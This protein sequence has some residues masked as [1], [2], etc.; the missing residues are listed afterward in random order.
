MSIRERFTPQ[1]LDT[2]R[3]Y[4]E[5]LQEWK[6]RRPQELTE[7]EKLEIIDFFKSHNHI[8]PAYEGKYEVIVDREDDSCDYEIKDYALERWRAE[9]DE[10][11]PYSEVTQLL[12]YVELEKRGLTPEEYEERRQ[13]ARTPQNEEELKSWKDLEAI[14]KENYEKLEIPEFDIKRAIFFAWV[15]KLPEKRQEEIYDEIVA[16]VIAPED[17]NEYKTL[18]TAIDELFEVNETALVLFKEN[19]PI[20]SVTRDEYRGAF[21]PTKNDHAYILDQGQL[22][23][24]FDENGEFKSLET[25]E[26]KEGLKKRL[27]ETKEA[28]A[29]VID[30]ALYATIA[31]A[32]LSS[33]PKINGHE[34][35]VYAPLFFSALGKQFRKSDFRE[36][37]TAQDR[38]TRHADVWSELNKLEGKTGYLDGKL[39]AVYKYGGYDPKTNILTIY[40]PYVVE[41]IKTMKEKPKLSKK[42]TVEPYYNLLINAN[43]NKE[44]NKIGVQLVL[45][46]VPGIVKR[47]II[48]DYEL[49]KENYKKRKLKDH[50][51]ITYKIS[52]SSLIDKTPLL[53]EAFDNAEAKNKLV[54]LNRALKSFEKYMKTDTQCFGKYKDFSI[55]I[56]PPSMKTLDKDYLTITHH[57]ENEDFKNPNELPD[58]KIVEKGSQD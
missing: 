38:K 18:I 13:K 31:S 55:T 14:Y 37:N 35:Q 15:K 7:I 40:T 8:Y 23:F 57:G 36:N 25:V 10:I 34:I 29:D 58:V 33:L 45:C 49:E 4:R 19:S 24:E 1:A 21:L 6:E 2:L 17:E 51:L 3:I 53:K 30:S 50:K 11:T 16:P 46:V 5:K 43:I 28:P 39:F 20:F 12:Y 41:L 44:K 56:T 42:G 52:Y 48:S 27:K 54:I 22:T 9:F 47:G 26:E 32:V